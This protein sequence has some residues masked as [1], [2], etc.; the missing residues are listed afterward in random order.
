MIR[1]T[2]LS[3]EA[4]SNMSEKLCLQWND[5]KDNVN[6]AFESLRKDLDFV[7][8]TLA[9]EDGEHVK[10]HKIIL[11]ASSPFFQNLF[12]RHKHAHLLIFMR[13]VNS[14]NLLAV[15]DF[16][17]LGETN[18]SQENLDSFLA[19][20]DDL[21]LK[22]FVGQNA[23]NE[24]DE[25]LEKVTSIP[26]K[27]MQSFKDEE[28]TSRSQGLAEE[29]Q[30]SIVMVDVVPKNQSVATTSNFSGNIQELDDTVRS[31]ME[32]TQNSTATKQH[33]LYVCKVCGYEAQST[34]VKYHIEANHLE[35]VML[36]CNFCEK[37]YRSRKALLALK[38]HKYLKIMDQL[39]IEFACI[40]YFI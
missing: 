38:V 7:D 22:G 10:A 15:I 14:E 35:G 24:N 36:P 34:H 1:C 25:G 5:Y 39:I 18:I 28:K 12:K 8:V 13:G 20:A 26:L 29:K 17:Y 2:G 33:R 21:Q 37:T 23:D 40:S 6:S 32:K 9:S 4:S 31:M 3:T 19:I 27:P 30:A 11:A 16:L